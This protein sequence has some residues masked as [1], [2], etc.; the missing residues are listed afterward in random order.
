MRNI[1]INQEVRRIIDN[2]L[3]IRKL[4][5]EGLINTLAL[6]RKILKDYNLNCTLSA[7]LSAI[8]R[9]QEKL[10]Y[11][12]YLKDVYNLLKNSTLT[13]KTKLFSVLLKKTG[14]TRKKLAKL[15][16]ELE[17]DETFVV[18]EVTKYLKIILDKRGKR[19]VE[20]LFLK[21][22]IIDIEENIGLLHMGYNI[23]VTKTPGVFALLANE[24]GAND[25]SI[26]DSMICHSEHIIIVR[27]KDI[28]KAF[29]IVFDLLHTKHKK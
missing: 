13:M 27:E 14:D 9:Y 24:L 21:K 17:P 18:F 25:I 8:R 15:Y 1:N 26:V 7:V 2:N 29:D 6:A 4:L 10:K 28:R 11:K 20:D 22:D 23:D 3:A 5:G 19:T 16:S 12:D